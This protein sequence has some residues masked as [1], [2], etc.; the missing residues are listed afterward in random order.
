VG[1]VKPKH[2]EDKISLL[3]KS[4]TVENSET[5]VSYHDMC[6]TKQCSYIRGYWWTIVVGKASE[7]Y[8]QHAT[9]P[10]VSNSSVKEDGSCTIA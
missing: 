8:N 9:V 1:K 3:V 7:K 4:I 2:K 10:K 6:S 5:H